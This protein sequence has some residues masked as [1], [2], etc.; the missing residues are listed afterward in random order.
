MKA[1]FVHVY[2]ERPG[3]KKRP[4]LL[5][6]SCFGI[7]FF[8]RAVHAL[9]GVRQ[10][11]AIYWI[12]PFQ[13]QAY[14]NSFFSS[15]N[16]VFER[17]IWKVLGVEETHPGTFSSRNVRFDPLRW[18]Q[19]DAF[20]LW[21]FE[22]FERLTS[23]RG[24]SHMLLFNLE[25]FWYLESAHYD[26][27]G[28]WLEK[29]DFV[30]NG[31]SPEDFLLGF[32]A[33]KIR[34]GKTRFELQR[35]KQIQNLIHNFSTDSFGNPLAR[36]EAL[37]SRIEKLSCRLKEPVLLKNVVHCEESSE[38]PSL[39]NVFYRNLQSTL[40]CISLR[41]LNGLRRLKKLEGDMGILPQSGNP[42]DS[43]N[44]YTRGPRS[45]RIEG[46]LS[47]FS[48][49]EFCEFIQIWKDVPFIRYSEGK[50]KPVPFSR[51]KSLKEEI[52]GMIW[53][54]SSF[55]AD[56]L[57]DLENFYACGVNG[58]VLK[59][60]EEFRAGDLISLERKMEQLKI[61]KKNHPEIFF[62]IQISNHN[63]F[64]AEIAGF[65]HRFQY[66]SDGI[67]LSGEGLC[68]AYQ[69][70][71]FEKVCRRVPY[72]CILR[73]ENNISLCPRAE[74]DFS[75]LRRDQWFSETVY[76]GQRPECQECRIQFDYGISG[77]YYS[78]YPEAESVLRKEFLRTRLAGTR[79]YLKDGKY[80]EA[81]E[82]LE[83]ILKINP[84]HQEA[85]EAIE[86][87]QKKVLS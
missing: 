86:E 51:L 64:Q 16:P 5:F 42:S 34:Y 7:P 52:E 57:R 3:L 84:L 74:K 71:H 20:G 39:M 63:N 31:G 56:S 72:E 19:E 58:F 10:F 49:E 50:D 81:L 73:E 14:F 9:A 6:E 28:Q 33:K 76:A 54:E 41:E 2:R 48:E 82:C 24:I 67:V 53:L 78:F 21:N 4:S 30:L 62:L 36:S 37:D 75:A 70:R 38:I 11:D 18:I 80:T 61:F 44:A 25:S 45:L 13:D 1:I 32:E 26:E 68:N 46:G 22:G 79:R 60:D 27:M 17:C 15:I 12:C 59:A 65:I 40:P 83:N 8:E 35:K 43:S 23:S 47:S 66:D 85:W 69:A 29:G 77:S 87:I 55:S